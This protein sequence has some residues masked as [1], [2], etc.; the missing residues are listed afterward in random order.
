MHRL[1]GVV[2]TIWGGLGGQLKVGEYNQV[3]SARHKHGGWRHIMPTCVEVSNDCAS[4]GIPSMY[5]KLGGR[6]VFPVLV[7]KFEIFGFL[8]TILW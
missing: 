6:V 2:R 5:F 4:F 1:G 7:L 3:A 8:L